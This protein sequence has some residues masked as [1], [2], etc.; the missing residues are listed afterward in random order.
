MMGNWQQFSL[1]LMIHSL[2]DLIASFSG[3][4]TVTP[5][6]SGFRKYLQVWK[7][8]GMRGEVFGL[9]SVIYDYDA[10]FLKTLL[11]TPI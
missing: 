1:P 3:P 8:M 4:I 11:Q 2:S 10:I 6:A 9:F 5:N 7:R